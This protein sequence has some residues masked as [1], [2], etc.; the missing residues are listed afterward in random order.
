[1]SAFLLELK[2]FQYLSS[3]HFS[4]NKELLVELPDVEIRHLHEIIKIKQN[5]T[6]ILENL[7]KS[8]LTELFLTAMFF[9]EI[10]ISECIIE[11]LTRWVF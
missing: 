2:H 8:D 4:E 5:S 10:R 1:M 6:Q 11:T 3:G 9:L 7:P